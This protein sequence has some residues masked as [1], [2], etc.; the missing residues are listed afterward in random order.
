M[1]PAE[2]LVN[3]AGKKPRAGWLKGVIIRRMEN[4]EKKG[5]ILDWLLRQNPLVVGTFFVI[6]IALLSNYAGERYEDTV[7]EFK[8]ANPVIQKTPPGYE[9]GEHAVV[10][11]TERGMG[12]LDEILMEQSVASVLVVFTVTVIVILFIPFLTFLYYYRKRR[13]AARRKNTSL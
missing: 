3:L 5:G 1:F 13:D 8:E 7:R 10:D 9:P 4:G 2:C 6:F 12:F 11:N